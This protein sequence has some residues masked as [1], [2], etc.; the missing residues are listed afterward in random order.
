VSYADDRSAAI[1]GCGSVHVNFA[2]KD[3]VLKNVLFVSS[4]FG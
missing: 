4:A 3:F 2:D 1:E